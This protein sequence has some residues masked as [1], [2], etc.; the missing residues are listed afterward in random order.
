MQT[1]IIKGE[2]PDL[3]TEINLAKKHW[4]YY[5]NHKKTWTTLI[6]YEAKKQLTK[7]LHPKLHLEFF[8][9]VKD[10]MKDPDN[11]CFAKKY[12]LDGIKEAGIIPNDGFRHIESFADF[13]AVDAKNPR[14]E[15][16]IFN[17]RKKEN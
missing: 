13:F 9:Y 15:V 4:S 11:L 1:L 16:N 2:L 12:L 3:N 10:K 8:W 17:Q 6:M 5:A 7:I 14:V